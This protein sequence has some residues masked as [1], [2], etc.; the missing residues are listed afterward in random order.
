MSLRRSGAA[1]EAEWIVSPS[2]G[3]YQLTFALPQQLERWISESDEPLRK[4][5]HTV[6][7][8]PLLPTGHG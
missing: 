4:R 1:E 8:V 3:T 5:T 2:D 7:A 6:K